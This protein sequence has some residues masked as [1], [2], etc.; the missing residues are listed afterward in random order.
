MDQFELISQTPGVVDE[1]N[2]YA[3]T[4]EIYQRR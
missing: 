3:H 4:F 1:R 2:R